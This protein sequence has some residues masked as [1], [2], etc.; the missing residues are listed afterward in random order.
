M[1]KNLFFICFYFLIS[2]NLK[3]QVAYDDFKNL[4]KIF[5]LEFDAELKQKNAKMIIN[6]PVGNDP[7]FWWKQTAIRASYSGHLDEN[8]RVIHYI[9]LFSGYA[10]IPGM[11]ITGLAMTLCHE[12]GHG[13]GGNPKK[14]SDEKVP[15]SVEGQADYFAARFCIKRIL[16]HLPNINAKPFNSFVQKR[17]MDRY[18]NLNDQ[19]MCYRAFRVL[20]KERLFFRMK[21][22]GGE[23]TSFDRTDPTVVKSVD[24]DPYFYPEPQCRLD[25][26]I[27]GLLELERPRCWWKQ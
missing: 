16:K 12:L 2:F 18:K 19:E 11:D 23:E 20:E 5:H 7:D 25:T 27:N 17:C 22:G 3:A 9:F 24:L 14:M 4:V 15:A 1:K 6:N 13:I 21:E 10:K 26:M 8:G